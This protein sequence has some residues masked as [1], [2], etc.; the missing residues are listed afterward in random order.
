M[1]FV[2]CA[3]FHINRVIVVQPMLTPELLCP[4]N[5]F[6]QVRGIYFQLFSDPYMRDVLQKR[7]FHGSRL[8]GIVQ[9]V[10]NYGSPHFPE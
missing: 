4:H 10:Y 7:S 8:K 9:I 6:I 2:L 1:M 3:K 5:H